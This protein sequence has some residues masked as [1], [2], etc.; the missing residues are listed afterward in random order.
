MFKNYMTYTFAINFQRS[1]Q[2][3]DLP[4]PGKASL[5]DSLEKMISCFS[6]SVQED[7]R[8]AELR[9]VGA[10]VFC[11]RDCHAILSRS[12]LLKGDIETLYYV[13]HKRTL[14]ICS[15]LADQIQS[16]EMRRFG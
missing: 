4:P 13:V 14:G 3:L 10:A 1:C 11:L 7:D 2:L 16:D 12:N 6:R 9:H 8:K 15:S 5:M